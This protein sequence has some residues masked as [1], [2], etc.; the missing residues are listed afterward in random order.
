MIYINGSK[1]NELFESAFN[2]EVKMVSIDGQSFSN[3]TSD[4]KRFL[5]PFSGKLM[6]F[7]NF[8]EGRKANEEK[9]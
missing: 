4:G 3:A 1:N 5:T 8:Q 6:I 7:D 2:R 9:P